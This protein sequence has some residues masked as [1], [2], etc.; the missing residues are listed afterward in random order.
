MLR[1]LTV[2]VL[3]DLSETERNIEEQGQLFQLTFS[4]KLKLVSKVSRSLWNI[5]TPILEGQGI[6]FAAFFHPI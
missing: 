5:M 6:F 4:E 1:T 3:R 2:T